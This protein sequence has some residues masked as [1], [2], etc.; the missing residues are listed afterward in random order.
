MTDR[1]SSPMARI[2]YNRIE[3]FVIAFDADKVLDTVTRP[4]EQFLRPTM[5]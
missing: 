4:K 5:V 2:R 1:N 3:N